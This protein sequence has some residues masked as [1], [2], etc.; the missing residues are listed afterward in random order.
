M[1][2]DSLRG[3]VAAAKVSMWI[4]LEGTGKPPNCQVLWSNVGRNYQ[5]MTGRF[6]DVSADCGGLQARGSL[7]PGP[8]E[9]GG[10]LFESHLLKPRQVAMEFYDVWP[11][12]TR[13]LSCPS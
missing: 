8:G 2:R 3:G 4:R 9:Q 12:G 10:E 11:S 5:A 1:T 6:R 7:A 13:I